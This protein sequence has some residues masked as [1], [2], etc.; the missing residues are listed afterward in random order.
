[1]L[2]NEAEIF[3]ATPR[4]PLAAVATAAIAASWMEAVSA[5]SGAA[6]ISEGIGCVPD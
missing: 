6:A 3:E 2:A 5:E 1:M 4:A